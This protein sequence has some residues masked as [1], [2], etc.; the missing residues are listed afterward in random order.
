ME[1]ARNPP[2]PEMCCVAKP[3][4]LR[5]SREERVRHA[6]GMSVVLV[7]D[8]KSVKSIEPA[9]KLRDCFCR[10]GA[11]ILREFWVIGE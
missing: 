10:Q 3:Q 4:W 1:S 5:M 6:Q 11:D 2:T 7:V 9:T 8:D